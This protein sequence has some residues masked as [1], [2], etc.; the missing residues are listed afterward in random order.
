[1]ENRLENQ[2]NHIL[3]RESILNKVPS[4]IFRAYR[5]LK[6]IEVKTFEDAF[7]L[8][9]F[10]IKTQKKSVIWIIQ[11]S[12]ELKYS[13]ATHRQRANSHLFPSLFFFPQKK[14]MKLDDKN[15]SSI[16]FLLST[17]R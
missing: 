4:K 8:K 1:M 6:Q 7:N 5:N 2:S 12:M 14:E 3:F 10:K 11:L 15:I 16:S 9:I 17:K 13:K